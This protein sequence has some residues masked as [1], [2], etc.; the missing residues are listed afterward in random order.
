MKNIKY[1]LFALFLL[2]P[3]AVSAD[4]IYNVEMDIKVDKNGAANIEE[5]WIV[6]A[7]DGSEWYKQYKNLGNIEIT[8]FNVSMDGIPLKEKEWDVDESLSEKAGYYGINTIDDGIELCFGKRDMSKHT[9]V[10]KYKMSNFVFNT[11]DAQVIYSTLFPNFKADNFKVTL[12]S[13]YDFPDKL[14]VWGFGYKGYAYV[15]NGVIEMS[16]E[17]GI[18]DEYVVLLAKFPKNTFETTN[19]YEEFTDFN[20]VLSKAKEGSFEYD[21]GTKKSFWQSLWDYI[22]FIFFAAVIIIPVIV[23]FIKGYSSGYGYKGNKKIIEK[24]VPMFRDIPC[25]KDI[26][27]GNALISLNN[28]GYKEGN[29]LG[30]MLLKWIK[31]D[32]ITIKNEKKGVFNK[33]TSTIDMRKNVTFDNRLEEDVFDLMKDASGDGI[34][35]PKEMERYCRTN[36]SRFLNLLKS[37]KDN[38]VSDLRKEG[39]IYSRKNKE[40]CKKSNVM[41]DKIY[42]DSVQ[43]LGLKKFLKEFSQIGTKEVM[44]VKIWDEFLMFAYLFG[45]ADKVAK[46]LKHLYPNG[47]KINNDDIYFDYGTL[48]FINTISTS[49]VNAAS[50]ARAAAES[51]SSGGGGFSSGGG[52]FGSFG[53]GGSMGG[54]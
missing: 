6:K 19:S 30:A 21:Y 24:E 20:S 2:I 43:L 3:F 10:L 39:H 5:T 7:S 26:Y 53:G 38:K 32:K 37:I 50:S 22:Y 46:Q 18:D 35:E 11:S 31:E 1:V 29:I 52:G 12:S 17:D 49:S 42:E 23:G 9:F 4:Q 54:R 15:K 45:I 47:L 8:D 51:Y 16:N 36:Y 25:G 14:D 41:D 48:L 28:F 44:E 13:Y 33:D 34:L 40:E 27:Y